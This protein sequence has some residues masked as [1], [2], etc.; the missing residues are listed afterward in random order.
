MTAGI[1]TMAYSFANANDVP[2]HRGGNPVTDKAVRKNAK[3][4]MRSAE[5]DWEVACCDLATVGDNLPVPNRAVYRYKNGV[6][7]ILN[8]VGPNWQP[9][10]NIKAFEWFQPWLDAGLAEFET[11]GSLFD[12]QRV[13]V[14]ARLALDNLEVAKGDEVMPF[15]LLSNTHG[16]GAVKGGF[17]PIRVVCYNTLSAVIAKGVGKMLRVRHTGNL[18]T[19][20]DLMRDCMNLVKQ[21]FEATAEQYRRL[22][23]KGFNEA[24]V[25][26]YVKI[27]VGAEDT[28]DDELATRTVNRM[29]GIMKLIF[30]GKGQDNPAISGTWWQAYNGYNEYLNYVE[31]RNRDNR[32]DNLWFGQGINKNADALQL[33]LDMAG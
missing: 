13:W 27:L 21:D 6:K 24:D 22:A 23:N 1:D 30:S 10:Q 12:G 20:L 32:M 7:T 15:I 11:A 18:Q 25:K 4:F 5:M 33:A 26:K 31:G 2:W 3:E 16:I 9:L 17:N 19:N 28:A 29:E 8:V 14:L